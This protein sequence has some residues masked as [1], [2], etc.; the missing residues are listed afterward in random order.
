MKGNKT[1]FSLIEVAIALLVV[2]VG[3]TALL[4]LFPHALRAGQLSKAE[5]AQVLFASAVFSAL[6]NKALETTDFDDWTKDNWL[7]SVCDISEPINPDIKPLKESDLTEQHCPRKNFN[8]VGN[9]EGVASYLM[10][11]R[12]NEAKTLVR[13]TL[14]SSQYDTTLTTVPKLNRLELMKRSTAFYTEFY[15][16]GKE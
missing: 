1:G 16:M 12:R 5:S 11:V 8:Y 13:I 7:K 10:N 15:Y 2:G 4:Q 3:F 9:Y 6:R 14:W